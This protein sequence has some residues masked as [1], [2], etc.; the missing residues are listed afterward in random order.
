MKN[1]DK[2]CGAKLCKSQ[3]SFS[4]EG[5]SGTSFA[6]TSS[7]NPKIYLEGLS[8]IIFFASFK[9]RHECFPAGFPVDIQLQRNASNAAL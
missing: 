7:A 3:D 4:F 5:L 6:G 9:Y 8:G 2:F 1:R